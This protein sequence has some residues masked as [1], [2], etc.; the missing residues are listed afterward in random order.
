MAEVYALQMLFWFSLV[1]QN[2]YT[3]ELYW[4]VLKIHKLLMQILKEHS[5]I[6]YN[7]N[8]F[9]GNNLFLF[10]RINNSA[11]SGID[12]SAFSLFIGASVCLLC[13]ATVVIVQQCR[14]WKKM[15]DT[16]R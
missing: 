1:L 12:F 13:S 9:I 4:D 7:Q 14:L 6:S 16:Y 8:R 5:I 2:F 15:H 11:Y 10:K 3:E